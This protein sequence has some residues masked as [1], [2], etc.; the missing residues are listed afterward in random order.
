VV[1]TTN[2]PRAKLPASELKF[3]QT[4]TDHMLV[5]KWSKADGW[6][7]PEIKPYGD[8]SVDPSAS[9]FHYATCLFEGMKAYKSRDG[10]IRLFR[11]EMNMARMNESAHRLAFPV[12]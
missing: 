5:V 9:V 6:K 8:L 12:L 11:P 10:K 2:A 4:F 1:K 7:A 3:G